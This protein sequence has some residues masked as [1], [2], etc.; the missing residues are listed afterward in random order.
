[1]LIPPRTLVIIP[2]YNEEASL[3]A[4]LK[5]L[6]EQTPEYDVLVVS[7][8]SWPGYTDVPNHVIEGYGTIFAEADE[9]GRAMWIALKCSGSLPKRFEMRTRSCVPP[10]DRCTIWRSVASRRS[11]AATSEFWGSASC[12]DAVQEAS[13]CVCA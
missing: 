5:E 2:A 11:S 7:D 1:M 3:P 13:Q 12:C 4:V 9:T 8:T 10:S 6:A